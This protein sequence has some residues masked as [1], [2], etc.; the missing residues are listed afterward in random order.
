M[1]ASAGTPAHLLHSAAPGGVDVETGLQ[2]QVEP[3]QWWAVS[4]TPAR[5]GARAT[6][7]CQCAC[8]NGRAVSVA[9]VSGRCVACL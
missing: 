4:D 5:L 2:S 8:V 1:T 9:R 7:V 6:R 3:R